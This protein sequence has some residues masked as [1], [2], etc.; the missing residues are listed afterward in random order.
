MKPKVKAIILSGVVLVLAFSIWFVWEIYTDKPPEFFPFNE[1]AA[2][3][4]IKKENNGMFVVN[5][6]GP[7]TF[8]NENK[9][10][11]V[12]GKTDYDLEQYIGKKIII[13]KGSFENN[14]T[15]QCIKEKCIDIGGPYAGVVIDE[16]N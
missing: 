16:I 1:S 3:Y 4:L 11:I 10:S 12:V 13:T 14:F 7:N 5:Y 6:K 15:K 2:D 8:N 9:V